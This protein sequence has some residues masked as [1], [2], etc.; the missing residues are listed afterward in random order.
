MS[1]ID[2]TLFTGAAEVACKWRRPLL[3]THTKP[4]GDALGSLVAARQL[5]RCGG[6][7]PIALMFD[8]LTSSY[9]VFKRFEAL[10]VLGSDVTVDQLD[11]VD[12]VMLLDTCSR[13]QI[14]PLAAW[15]AECGLPIIA[16]DHHINR[17]KLADHYVVDETAGAACLILYEWARAM[18]WHIDD[19][20]R[21]ALF[22]GIGTDTGWFRFS[23]T[24]TRIL[25]AAAALTEAGVRPH[26]LHQGLFQRDTAARVKLLGAAIAS[27]EVLQE[28][29]LAMMTLTDAD[30]E[31][32]GAGPGDTENIVNEPLRIDTVAVSVILVD[33]Q[34]E[35]VKASFRSKPPLCGDIPDIDVATLAN[36]LGGGGH[37]RAAAARIEGT[38]ADVKRK[39]TEAITGLLGA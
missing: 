6:A 4:D 33:R 5:L 3:I 14:R 21:D 15:L 10:P 30:Y 34:N 28:G 35:P 1:P 26:E 24:D 31:A 23:N 2:Q 13:S 12:G 11:G 18:D 32:T 17:D 27:L 8:P 29:R 25:Q 7:D 19:V 39:V 38:L 37:R 36:A 20:T 22:I 9:A 16:V